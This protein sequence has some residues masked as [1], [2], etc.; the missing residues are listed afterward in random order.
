MSTN[1]TAPQADAKNLFVSKDPAR[2]RIRLIK[3]TAARLAVSGAF[4]LAMIPLV[5]LIWTVIAK[6]RLRLGASFLTSDMVGVFGGLVKGGIAHAIV[7]TLLITLL[8]TLISAP[9]GVFTAIYLVEYG[10]GNLLAKATTFFVDVMTGIPSIVAGLFSAA[11]FTIAVGSGYRAGVMGALALSILMVP[12]VVS[13]SEEMLRLVPNELREA[14]YALGVPKWRTIV[15][16]VLRTSAAG[17]TTSIML[18]LARVIGETAPLL[19]TVGFIEKMNANPIV[20]RM[21]TLPVYVY[22]QY[23][24]GVATCRAGA[25]N[26]VPTINEERAWS[27]A[28]VLI[29]LVMILNVI[30]RV[31][32]KAFA[33][34]GR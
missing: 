27:A 24:Q 25:A 9:I 1:P 30:A 16:V 33:P 15:K 2:D 19:I 7:G 13:S 31:I 26:C 28:L 12:T 10:R 34:K 20:G 3:D 17:L 14:A 21:T 18:A 23:S 22:R 11:L 4:L 5:S 32:A 29:V 6:G 8:A